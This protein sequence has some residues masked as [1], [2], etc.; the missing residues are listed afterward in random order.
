MEQIYQGKHFET[1]EPITILV[2]KGLIAAI[3]PCTTKP[4][5]FIAPGLIDNQVNGYAGVGFT[6]PGLRVPDIRQVIK[7]LHSLGVTTFL[8]TLITASKNLLLQ[9]LAVINEACSD[10]LISGSIAGIH[11]EGPFISNEDGFR[12][13]HNS[14]YVR[15]PD[16]REFEKLYKTS[17]KRICHLTLAPELDGAIDLI[18]LCRSMGVTVGMAHHNARAEQINAAVEAGAG[19]AVHLGN[20]LAN[21]LERHK[22]PIWAQL[23]NDNLIISMI[24]DGFHLTPEEMKTY[25][26]VKGV[27]KTILTSDCTDL[28]GLPPGDYFWDGKNVKLEPEGVIRYPA[29]NVLAGAAS[30]LIRDLAIMTQTVGCSLSD[31][32]L[33]ATRNPARFHNLDDRGELIVGKRADFIT[34]SLKNNSIHLQNTVKDGKLMFSE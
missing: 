28:A 22:N 34:Y 8:P 26:K 17:G 3:K 7:A 18:R 27:E 10:P 11:L 19:L 5:Y 4:G 6:Q 13:A 12:G 1:G 15:L 30:P 24:A 21:M 23:A 29:Q 20:G 16:Q 25:Y 14:E 2:E 9:N 31:S 33:M 32:I